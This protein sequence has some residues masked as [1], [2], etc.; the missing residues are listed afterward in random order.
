MTNFEKQRQERI[1]I[2]RASIDAERR[3]LETVREARKQREAKH[4]N[5]IES[6]DNLVVLMRQMAEQLERDAR[7]SWLD[8]KALRDGADVLEGKSPNAEPVNVRSRI[9]ANAAKVNATAA[10][11]MAAFGGVS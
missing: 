7:Q 11:I 8:A 2:A 4:A 3:R 6:A 5:T 9:E 1:A 10:D